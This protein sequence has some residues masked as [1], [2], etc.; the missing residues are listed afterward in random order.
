M[1]MT[2]LFLESEPIHLK[3]L[4]WVIT[5]KSVPRLT[6]CPKKEKCSHQKKKFFQYKTGQKKQDM[7][8]FTTTTAIKQNK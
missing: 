3:N 1:K 4:L 5:E 6:A 8:T 7:L 2:I